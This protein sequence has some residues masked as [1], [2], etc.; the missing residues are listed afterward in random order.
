MV[1][2]VLNEILKLQE[3]LPPRERMVKVDV[4]VDENGKLST[5]ATELFW[6]IKNAS[7]SAIAALMGT[8]APL[9]DKEIMPL[10]C[11]DLFLG[12]LREFYLNKTITKNAGILLRAIEPPFTLCRVDWRRRDLEGFAERLSGLPANRWL[13]NVVSDSGPSGKAHANGPER[14]PSHVEENSTRARPRK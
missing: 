11:A 12:E 3:H 2:V 7:D 5:R 8:A 6:A 10:Q 13:S 9:D 1:A 14:N 4:F